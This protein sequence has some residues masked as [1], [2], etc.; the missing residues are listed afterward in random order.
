VQVFASSTFILAVKT[1]HRSVLIPLG[2]FL[3]A[4]EGRT[5][6]ECLPGWRSNAH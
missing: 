4:F 3:I 2:G 6:L 5:G 1:Y